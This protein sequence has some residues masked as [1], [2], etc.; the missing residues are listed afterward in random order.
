MI[1]GHNH[2]ILYPNY[3]FIMGWLKCVN[4]SHTYIW[5]SQSNIWLPRYFEMWYYKSNQKH[6]HAPLSLHT[7]AHTGNLIKQT[8]KNVIKSALLN[9]TAATFSLSLAI[10]TAFQRH[11]VYSKK[12]NSTNVACALRKY[13]CC[14]LK[15]SD[16]LYSSVTR[17]HASSFT[18][19]CIQWYRSRPVLSSL[20]N[21]ARPWLAVATTTLGREKTPVSFTL[22]QDQICGFYCGWA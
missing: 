17:H 20:P 21:S 4:D 12:L 3:N 22:D 1:H 13:A 7:L 16:L 19:P 9:H 2:P 18:K 14:L 6:G 15:S 5:S 11:C 10:N 8:H